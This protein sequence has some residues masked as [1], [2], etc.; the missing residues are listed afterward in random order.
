MIGLVAKNT[1]F[2]I[3][4]YRFKETCKK[5]IQDG[6]VRHPDSVLITKRSAIDETWANHFEKLLNRP[7]PDELLDVPS[8]AFLKLDINTEPPTLDELLTATKK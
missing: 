3:L 8:I 2:L 6:P 1:T 4:L 7:P 5:S